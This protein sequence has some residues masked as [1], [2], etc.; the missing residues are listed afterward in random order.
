MHKWT[1]VFL[2]NGRT[3]CSPFKSC[4]CCKYHVQCATV[5]VYN[6]SRAADSLVKRQT[7]STRWH[8]KIRLTSSFCNDFNFI[9]QLLL[10]LFYSF[11]PRTLKFTFNAIRFANKFLTQT[12]TCFNN[13]WTADH[14]LSEDLPTFHVVYIFKYKISASV[15]YCRHN[16]KIEI[17]SSAHDKRCSIHFCTMIKLNRWNSS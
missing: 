17:F 6:L 5:F 8:Q 11:K 3:L 16:L 1:T 13:M 12:P 4:K 10:I 2:C 15:E 14:R 7:N 9:S